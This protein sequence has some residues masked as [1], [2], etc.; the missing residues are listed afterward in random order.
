MHINARNIVYLLSYI[1][2]WFECLKHVQN[3]NMK[4]S[5]TE[6]LKVINDRV[7]VAR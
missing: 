4:Y 3:N 2:F 5:R 7:S 6:D 1:V